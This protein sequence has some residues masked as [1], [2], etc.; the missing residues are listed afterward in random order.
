MTNTSEYNP[1]VFR[2]VSFNAN[3]T[4]NYTAVVLQRFY[5][6]DAIFIQEPSYSV[7][8]R[9]PSPTNPLGD[10]FYGTQAQ[11]TDWLLLEV[12][13]I[14]RARV[15]C[16]INRRWVGASPRTRHDIISHPHLLCFSLM[17][18]DTERFFLNVYSHPDNHEGTKALIQAEHLPSFT[19]IAGDFNLHHTLWESNR[20]SEPH[21]QEIVDFMP[22][23]Q[24]SL[25]NTPDIFTHFPH[26]RSFQPSV[27]DLAWLNSELV[28][29][30]LT[31]LTIDPGS[32]MGSDH[33]VLIIDVPTAPTY[34][35]SPRIR[36]GSE[37]EAEFIVDVIEAITHHS[38]DSLSSPLEIET[39][40]TALF[41]L[42]QEAFDRHARI[43]DISSHSKPWW[44]EECQ[45]A[46]RRLRETNH[47]DDRWAFYNAVRAAKRKHFDAVIAEMAAIKRPW[48]LTAWS[49]PR[50]ISA[51][52]HIQD[53]NG[54]VIHSFDHFVQSCTEQFFSAHDRRV[55]LS[56]V[57]CLPRQEERGFPPFS[58]KEMQDA[59]SGTTSRSA[60]GPDHL[61]W[62]I[63]K[64]L[65]QDSTIASFWPR[66]FNSCVQH[67]HW[68][69]QFKS[70]ITVIIP[71]PK[72]PDYSV[73]KAYRPIVLLSCMGKLCEKMIA[74]RM[75]YDCVRYR[76]L[77]PSQCGGI[78]F[79][80][81]DDA[82]LLL[83]HHLRAARA[84]GLH[85]TCLAMDIAQ[86]F[87]SVNHQLLVAVLRRLGF[88]P[89]LCK[90]VE[91]YLA[92]RTTQFRWS[93][94]LSEPVGCAVGVGQG[95]CLSPLF[96]ALAILPALFLISRLLPTP[97]NILRTSL[98][99]FVDDG[100][101]TISTDSL[102]TNIFLLKTLYPRVVSVFRRIGIILELDKLELCHFPQARYS[103]PLPSLSITVE[104]STITL[105][106]LQ[107]WRYLGFF[108]DP[109]L[110]FQH[111]VRYYATKALS[112]V[113]GYPL[114]GNS[115][116]GLAPDQKRQLCISCVLP[117]LTYGFR[118]WY[119]P[120][121]PQKS[122]IA[123][124]SRAQAAAARW[125][126]GAFRTSPTGGMEI[127]AG[128]L[129]IHLHI[130]RPFERSILRFQR[131]P[132]SHIVSATASPNGPRDYSY[133]VGF[134]IRHFLP[135]SPCRYK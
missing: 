17:F 118:L 22:D 49:K 61:T 127:L 109:S 122:L 11:S 121:K 34:V 99:F 86:F 48:D 96:S 54:N 40:L 111:H 116:R 95:S 72:K 15:A 100:I 42:I 79:H 117:I 56:V 82:G 78:S 85:S 14:H 98:L 71:K 31:S 120:R 97:S 47:L 112:T 105:R 4:A 39:S 77:H 55:D 114:L 89:S 83:V 102:G 50:P 46:L 133:T 68:P 94:K 9:V 106:P 64:F 13:D 124:L 32:R 2:V 6:A 36:P 67:S 76:L 75:Q 126:L 70:S 57:E 37:E 3:H 12:R 58:I 107:V 93:D 30:P 131:L 81:T 128:L 23:V 44:N 125:I 74:K 104:G 35:A 60:P 119:N 8:K 24:V 65:C 1:Q 29:H 10:E 103:G 63:I 33:A 45:S 134:P 91:S 52:S 92:G 88:N 25:L 69:A 132:N 87:P 20:R 101:L 7:L 123:M 130:R 27:I 73:L 66:V 90:L 5:Y 26:R 108:L 110:K 28:D 80:S 84:A 129:P 113:R 18:G 53:R 21:A 16:Y 41:S 59:L 51:I 43:P 19:L 135:R 115:A 38:N 62:P